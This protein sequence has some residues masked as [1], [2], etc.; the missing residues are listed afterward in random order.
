MSK[1]H[2]FF[3]LLSR[4]IFPHFRPFG[5]YGTPHFQ[6]KNRSEI[7][8][9]N[10]FTAETLRPLRL[11]LLLLQPKYLSDNPISAKSNARLRL[12]ELRHIEVQQ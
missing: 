4:I 10:Y 3:A 12:G 2:L 9:K 5:Q 8:W 7:R 11:V 6:D 1:A